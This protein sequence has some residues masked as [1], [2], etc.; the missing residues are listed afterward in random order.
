MQSM[1]GSHSLTEA[2]EQRIADYSLEIRSDPQIMTL[3]RLFTARLMLQLCDVFSSL[4]IA[5]TPGSCETVNR[6]KTGLF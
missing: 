3:L 5:G 6:R 1:L 4:T 2:M